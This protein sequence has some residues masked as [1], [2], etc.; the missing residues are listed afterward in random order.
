MNSFLLSLPAKGSFA[1]LFMMILWQMGSAQNVGIGTLT[2]DP[3]AIL[4]V[5]STETGLLIPRMTAAQRIVIATP[6]EGLLVYQIDEMVGYYFFR[7]GAWIPIADS[8]TVWSLNGNAGTIDGAHFIGTTDDVPL[9]FKVN[10]NMAGRIDHVL[11]NTFFGYRA[12]QVTTGANNT[13][14][15]TDALLLNTDGESNT[16]IGQ[17][18]LYYNTSG[19]SNTA[20]GFQTLESN[21]TGSGNTGTGANTLLS[22]GTGSFNTGYGM[23]SLVINSSG[24]F[25]TANGR[26][27]LYNNDTGS[28]NTAIGVSALFTNSTGTYNT[29]IGSGAN[30]SSGNL[31]NASA[32][33]AGAM[34]TASNTIQLGD[35]AVTTVNVGTGT[36]ATLVTGGI[37]VTAGTPELGKLLI[38][39]A[40]GIGSW[41]NG[42]DAFV[43]L[44][45]DQTVE[46]N[47]TIVNDVVIN[48]L[49][50]GK[51]ANA[52]NTNTA[53][54]NL[55]L[56]NITGGGYN[57]AVGYQS[58][59]NNLGGFENTA[60]GNALKIN[61]TGIRNTAFGNA[62]LLNNNGSNNTAVGNG[63]LVSNSTGSN[64]TSIGANSNVSSGALTNATAIGS[65]AVVSASNK[66]RLGNAAVSVI[67]GQVAYTFP[68]DGR[69]K[70]NISETDV[71][72]LSFIK[73]LR[74]VVYNF[75]TEKF[76]AYTRKG[77]P[78]DQRTGSDIIDFG[79]SIMIRQSGFIAQEVE[80]SAIEA[81]YD[82]NG[83]HKPESD[84]DYYSLSY[85]Q[86]VVPLVKGMQEQQQLIEAL[87]KQIDVQQQQIDELGMLVGKLL[88]GDK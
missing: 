78:A 39:D 1:F 26:G 74:P 15:G 68:S 45:T 49:T 24:D 30:V 69:F 58:L 4:D 20:N 17:H 50:V 36:T 3:S 83:L 22:N 13:A 27:S 73:T 59:L 79:P 77:M 32:I 18:A 82:F 62:A 11:A 63:S 9:T 71:K 12:G 14:I 7:T 42:A 75:D 56:N 37:Q 52:I 10:N 54:G 41:E 67:E 86:F 65:G 53:I 21:S 55:A 46:G 64:N 6:A 76:D 16:A 19:S 33:G 66:I 34:V 43:D 28:Y 48:G 44:T 47:K 61:T 88:P 84:N 40:S 80:E 8:E 70:N 85:S 25:N 35:E 87:Q 2:P 29:A 38:S 57:T 72:G 81:G 23:E 5:N 60:M 31:I 51:G